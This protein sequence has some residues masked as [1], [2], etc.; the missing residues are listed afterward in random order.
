M[1]PGLWDSSPALGAKPMCGPFKHWRAGVEDL[2]YERGGPGI[3]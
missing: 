3:V 2:R 1:A